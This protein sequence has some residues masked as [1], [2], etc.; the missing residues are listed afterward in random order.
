MTVSGRFWLPGPVEVDA[1]VLAAMGRPMIGHRTVAGHA[2]AERLQHGLRHVFHTDRPVL[3]TTGSATAMMEAAVRG[4]VRDRLLAIVSGTFGERFAQIAERADREVVRLHVP[5]G[6]ALEPAQLEAMLDGPA[7]DAVSMVHVETS[8]GALAPVAE[9]IATC[10]ALPDVVTI[11]DAVASVGAMPVDPAGWDADV[12][13]G[14][15]QKGLA[16]P[17]GLAFAVV[18]DR[19][20]TRATEV[21]DRGL[22]L[23]AVALHH[24]AAGARFPQTP[25]LPIAYALDRQLERIL[26]GDLD[27]RFARHRAMREHLE[28]WDMVRDDVALMA[29]VGRRADTVSV[30]RLPEGISAPTLVAD[31]ASDGYQVAPGLDHDFDHAIRIGH[32][33]EGSVDQLEHLLAAIDARL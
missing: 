7:I 31:L 21:P 2:L 17:P 1:D 4:A 23:D 30:L 12:V 32:M 18:S 10:R 16:C 24:D 26:E 22:Y 15:S 33:G 20:L 28:Q 19:F 6:M 11:V 13:I 14:G 9:L 29:P 25:A 5:R 8:T 3:L 27:A